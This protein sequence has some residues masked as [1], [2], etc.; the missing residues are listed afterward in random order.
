MLAIRTDRMDQ[1]E[2]ITTAERALREQEL[3]RRIHKHGDVHHAYVAQARPVDGEPWQAPVY[4]VVCSPLRDPLDARERRAIKLAMTP[5][6]ERLAHLLA[7]AAGVE[8]EPLTWEIS[9][10]PWF[11][12]QVATLDLDG[13]RCTFTLEKAQGPADE[14]PLIER[15]AATR[16]A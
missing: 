5:A 4:Q 14:D 9:D 3:L 15:V 12:N 6:A 16:L 2:A 10:G 8:G 13:R 7:R 1:G 11:D